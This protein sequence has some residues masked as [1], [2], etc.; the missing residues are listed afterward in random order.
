MLNSIN[1][2]SR[3]NVIGQWFSMS[4]KGHPVD[5]FLSIL[6][7]D[8]TSR[9]NTSQGFDSTVLVSIPA[10]AFTVSGECSFMHA[11]YRKKT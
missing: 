11:I 1:T 6:M 3:A 10:K 8:S 7:K 4:V 9:A 2:W 5:L